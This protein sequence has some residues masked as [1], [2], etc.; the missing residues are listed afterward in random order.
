MGRL[1]PARVR[2]DVFEPALNDL[3]IAR[4]TGSSARRGWAAGPLPR[5]AYAVGVLL[6]VLDCWRL[7]ASSLLFRGRPDGP[8]AH[9]APSPKDARAMWLYH[10]GQALRS[11]V[12]VPAF[13]AATVV[14]LALG[15]GAVATVA[16][17]ADAVLIRPLP[18][19][20][21]DRL[22]SIWPDHFLANRELD[23]LRQATRSYTDVASFSPGWLMTL[24]G[25]ARPRQVDAGRLSGNLLSMLGVAPALGRTFGLD[26]ETPGH[27]H[28]VVL[29]DALWRKEFGADPSITSRSIQLG[30]EA[31][32][33]VGVMPPGF[34]VAGATSDLWVPMTMDPQEMAWA[35]ATTLAYG[36]LRPEATADSATVE[37][38]A[39]AARM[40][41]DFDHPDSW[42][43]GATVA[44]L[45]D[46]VTGDVRPTLVVLLIAVGCLLSLAVTNVA[47]LLL[48][49]SIARRD[50]FGVRL[51]LG[52]TPRQLVVLLLSEAAWL[53]VLGCGAGIG[54]ACAGV[55]LLR[56][57][58]PPDVPR[59]DEVAVN[60][61]VLGLVAA[62]LAVIALACVAAPAVQGL[63]GA[64]PVRSGRTT[65]PANRTRGVFVATE[66]ALAVTLIF[67]ASLMARTLVSLHD[68]DR[69]LRSDHLLTLHVLASGTDAELRA[70]WT[71]VLDEVEAVPGVSSAATLL[72]VPLG[73]RS[74]TAD[75]LVDGRPPAPGATPPR[76]TWESVSSGYFATAGVPLR[77]G[78]SFS[79]ADGPSAPRVIAV[80]QALVDR[81]FPDEDPIGKRVQAGNATQGKLATIV[82]VV[83]NVR[84]RSLEQPAGPE[85]YVPFSQRTVYATFLLVRT[86]GDPLA[87]APVVE[88]RV[89][90]VDATVPVDDVRAMDDLY[91]ASMQQPRMLLI[92]FAL[93]AGMGLL[94]GAVGI[95]A[96]VAYGARQR[97][98]EI[99]IRVALGAGRA[100]VQ[101]LM[102]V[103]GVRY[104]V[105]GL[106]VGLPAA[107][108]LARFMRSL[109]FGVATSD[110]LSLAIVS[111][112][113]LPVVVLAGW[114]P[115]RRAAAANPAT[116]LRS[117]A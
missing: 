75:I 37:L 35:G 39:V 4:L 71:Q 104:T 16:S 62:L 114:L 3:A 55:G 70:Y 72:H 15:V 63:R 84:H 36:R 9:A 20:R 33:V 26:A 57:L 97:R 14:T 56:R 46:R 103:Q 45:K 61:P 112:T 68:V 50:E 115:A 60:G 111:L 40:Q 25:I 24:G 43:A 51:S 28:V 12:K 106:A 31:Y 21:P 74:W 67:G 100:S 94:L 18:Y 8:A 91:A 47:S 107:L 65:T 113:V 110:P 49:R 95:Y 86:A 10:A 1:L 17:I 23:R 32:A 98:R 54:L 105:A 42:G 5:V 53:S 73:G 7:A 79:D 52:A 76:A 29:S 117:D 38:T 19:A 48:V 92:V 88:D 102:I 41:S 58:A 87:V 99:G 83:G 81:I 93:F 64:W 80:N 77:R 89:R 11:L 13:T 59:L 66:V 30:G 85:V 116:V 44:P 6:L 27:D 108:L 2:R 22:V 78:R 96:L 101:R 34:R 82:G 90:A 69:G 109:V